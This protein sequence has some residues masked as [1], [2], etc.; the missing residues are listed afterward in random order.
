MPESDSSSG[1]KTL[2]TKAGQIPVKKSKT[3]V[4]K[5]DKDPLPQELSVNRI[6]ETAMAMLNA[7]DDSVFLLDPEGVILTVNEAFA[8]RFGTEPSKLIN[9]NV[10]DLFPDDV[11]QRRQMFLE[12]AIRTGKPM[13]FEDERAGRSFVTKVYPVADQA[14][15]I[16]RFV[17]YATDVTERKRSEKALRE[18]EERWE[19]MAKAAFEGLAITEKGRFIDVNDQFCAMT[20]YDRME[21][22]DREVSELLHEDD[23][24]LITGNIMADRES[25]TEH[26]MIHKDGRVVTVEA[27]PKMVDYKGR[28]VRFVALQDITER[29]RIEKELQDYRDELEQRIAKRTA[30]LHERLSEIE[31]YYDNAPVGLTIIDRRLRHIRVNRKL[32]EMNGIPP[33][34]HIGRTVA[35]VA[36]QGLADWLETVVP[37]IMESGETIRDVE[38]T[39]GVMGRPG[40]E[41]T[42]E[43]NL[44]PVKD[45]NGQPVAIGMTVEDV[46]EKKRF[47]EELRQSHKM[48]AIGTLAGG[49]AHDFNNM[50]AIIMGNAE[51]ALDDVQQ[52]EPR[53]NLEAILGAS[54]RSRDLVRQ[55]LAFS[56]KSGDEQKPVHMVDLLKETQKLLRPSL[57][58]TIR[59]NLDIHAA[60]DTAV[61]GN[62]SKIQQ[63]I[64]NLASNAAHAMRKR[65]GVLT[66]GLSTVDLGADSPSEAAVLG[67]YVKMTVR[68]TG[69]GIL[70]E[71]RRRMFEPFFTTKEPGQGS[72]M[73]LSVVYGIVK[74][75]NGMIEVE[76]KVGKGTTFTILF[77]QI[78]PA[79]AGR[80]EHQ[81]AAAGG[82]E[83]I[84]LIDD[85]EGFVEMAVPILERLGY[86]VTSATDS[87]VAMR[88][89][90]TSPDAFDLVI[91]DQTMPDFTGI[92]LAREVRHIRK[93]L[94]VILCTG[95]SEMVSPEIAEEAGVAEF[96]V[97]PIRKEQMAQAIRRALDK[98]KR[99]R[100]FAH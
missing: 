23:R 73:G 48:E 58:A 5:R 25:I 39:H 56:R 54:K 72:G 11:A 62:T 100:S 51:L 64:L 94:P 89:F 65:G 22:L 74:D 69:T 70:P 2:R 1:P 90:I 45:P 57:L 26:R 8:R 71:I 33:E 85:E 50:L 21:L 82:R 34:A 37:R 32:A 28:K 15:Q 36:D 75:L 61:M 52:P 43:A 87:I 18:S 13:V 81:E 79:P 40:V 66:I 42:T 46:T 38:Q 20:G 95:Y 99:Q 4:G 17:V 31:G 83:R 55:I 49:I 91:T 68:D 44:F 92:E 7:S 97:K 78:Y 93:D 24:A 19:I 47:E 12:E 67:T 98:G 53:R 86:Q 3:T 63:I 41:I 60:P 77:P 80:Q 6:E 30:E 88:I 84:L 27:H 16:T 76:S 96:L 59:I 9:R 14:G 10:F 35:E 29:K